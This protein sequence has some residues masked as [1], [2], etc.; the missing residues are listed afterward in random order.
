MLD[1]HSVSHKPYL[2]N[3]HLLPQ[4]LIFSHNQI[5]N[6]KIPG[7]LLNSLKTVKSGGDNR[8]SDPNKFKILQI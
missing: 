1:F 2:F 8:F 4:E 7:A 6:L 3:I 5:T